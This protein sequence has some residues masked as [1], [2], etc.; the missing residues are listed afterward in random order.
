M[1]NEIG[2]YV[3]IGIFV[4]AILAVGWVFVQNSGIPIPGWFISIVLILAAAVL[5]GGAVKILMK[6]FQST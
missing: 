4:V 2:R 5:T 3:L 6:M 1:V